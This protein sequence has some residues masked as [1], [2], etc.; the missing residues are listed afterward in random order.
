M[1]T[2]NKHLRNVLSTLSDESIKEVIEKYA[3]KVGFNIYDDS[4]KDDTVKNLTKIVKNLTKIINAESFDY[5]GD[6]IDY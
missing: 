5:K 6:I 4:W 2:T 1:D 3:K